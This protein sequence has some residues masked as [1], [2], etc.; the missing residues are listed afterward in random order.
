MIAHHFD[1]N[2]NIER[3]CLIFD[4]SGS[5]ATRKKG[6]ENFLRKEVNA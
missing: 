4:V 3:I 1:V 6:F 2:A 5:E